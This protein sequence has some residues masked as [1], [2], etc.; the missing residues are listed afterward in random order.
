M[1]MSG[2]GAGRTARPALT[3]LNRQLLLDRSTTTADG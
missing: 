2:S 1:I 3:I